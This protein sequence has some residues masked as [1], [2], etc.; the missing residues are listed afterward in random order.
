MHLR[1]YFYNIEDRFHDIVSFVLRDLN[2]IIEG[3]PRLLFEI[4]VLELIW[5]Y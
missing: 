1:I 3:L 5:I 4:L 2:K